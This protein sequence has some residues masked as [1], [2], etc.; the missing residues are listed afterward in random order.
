MCLLLGV[1]DVS[2]SLDSGAAPVA[3]TRTGDVS[4]SGKHRE[5]LGVHLDANFDP[6]VQGFLILG[7]PEKH[8]TWWE[9]GIRIKVVIAPLGTGHEL[10][11]ACY[12]MGAM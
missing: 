5:A 10:C 11:N 4:S 12:V 8:P 2:L 3:G 1:S 9:L 7:A 6:V